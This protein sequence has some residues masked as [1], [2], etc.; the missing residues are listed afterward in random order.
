MN[1][2]QT[3]WQTISIPLADFA[4]ETAGLPPLDLSKVSSG[5]IISN[6]DW[7]GPA[8]NYSDKGDFVIRFADIRWSATKTFEA[9]QIYRRTWDRLAAVDTDLDGVDDRIYVLESAAAL[10]A[11][12]SCNQVVNSGMYG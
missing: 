12:G 10:G 5:L 6:H 9:N 4:G 3:G 2:T 11:P 8:P 7:S 1:I